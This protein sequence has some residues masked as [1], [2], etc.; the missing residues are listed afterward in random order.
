MAPKAG[1]GINHG[2][3]AAA[4]KP[5]HC[6]RRARA[7]ADSRLGHIVLFS[8]GAGCADRR[9]HRLVAGLGDRRH[10]A[11]HAGRRAGIAAGRACDRTPRWPSGPDAEFAAVCRRTCDHRA[12]AGRCRFICWAGWWSAWRWGRGSTTRLSLRS[13]GSTVT[14]ARGPITN[15]TLFGGFA[16][17]ICWPLSAFLVELVGWRMTCLVY[18]VLHLVVALPLQRV[19]PATAVPVPA[20]MNR[21]ANGEPLPFRQRGQKQSA[22]RSSCWRW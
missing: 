20:S 14:R 18:V 16:S 13:D 2:R 3:G 10:L 7:C 21:S 9:R 11:R 4:T 5:A 12:R 1:A 6:R 22:R 8:G 17:T 15:L 19:M